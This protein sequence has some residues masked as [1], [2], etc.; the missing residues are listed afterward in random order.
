MTSLQGLTGVVDLQ[1]Y[2]FRFTLATTT[3]LIF[4]RPFDDLEDED[5][6]TC[7]NT[8]DY[9]SSI[10]AILLRLADLH[11]LYTPTKFIKASDNVK[12]YATHFVNK[13]LSYTDGI[14]SSQSSKGIALILNLYREL[15]DPLPVRDQLICRA[16]YYSMHHVMGIVSN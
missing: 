3:A 15:K 4:G 10:S 14:S 5:R 2:F 12:R 8:F 11:W 6:N 1:P 13:A 9:A 7:A 16:R